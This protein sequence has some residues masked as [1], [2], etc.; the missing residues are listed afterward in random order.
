MA[1]FV[2]LIGTPY[3][4]WYKIGKSVS[5]EIRVQDIGILLPFKIEI[6][7][8]WRA[9]NHHLLEST[10]HE[11]YKNNRINGEWFR[12]KRIEV[13]QLFLSLPESVRIFPS[14]N[15]PNSIFGKFSNVERDCPE[16]TKINFRI[17]KDRKGFLTE[18]ER[19]RL[20]SIDMRRDISK[21]E[22]KEAKR[23]IIHE[24]K[25]KF[26]QQKSNGLQTSMCPSSL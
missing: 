5:P 2:Y 13:K 19:E 1:G 14:E 25:I 7:G 24:A 3:F 15:N 22:R 16:G 10:L 12:F 20:K 23:K 21:Q 9:E 6:I 17:V 8:I 18:E 11:M 4:G 26:K